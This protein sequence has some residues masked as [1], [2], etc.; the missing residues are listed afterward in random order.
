MSSPNITNI[1]LKTTQQNITDSLG[2]IYGGI[3]RHDYV[4]SITKPAEAQFLVQDVNCSSY[5]GVGVDYELFYYNNGTKGA[6]I[7]YSTS[8]ES[9]YG[10]GPGSVLKDKL[11]TG[12]YDL[13]TTLTESSGYW[14]NYTLSFLGN[15]VSTLDSRPSTDASW[16]AARLYQA[17][18]G[19][20]PDQGGLAYWINKL[21]SGTS[22][23]DIASG[24]VNSAEFQSKFGTNV[25]QS[26]LVT[27]MYQNVLQRQPDAGGLNYW[28][29]KMSH[30][31]TAAQLVTGFTESPEGIGLLG[32][33]LSH[34]G[35]AGALTV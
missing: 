33:V 2:G 5:S 11:A 30:G 20:A 16:Q 12:T 25:S 27:E 31:M 18:L 19:R 22:L 13:V 3:D 24:F 23:V 8:H 1:A 14:Y 9:G 32:Q 15:A 21:S 4:F 34:S 29:D 6:R 35:A 26:T 17:T 7:D 10:A 28:I